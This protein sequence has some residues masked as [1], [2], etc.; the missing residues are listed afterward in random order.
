ML[1]LKASLLLS[2]TL[3]AARLLRRAPAVTRHGLWSVA[4]AAVLALPLLTSALPALYVPVPAGWA[5]AA[6]PRV[7]PGKVRDDAGAGDLSTIGPVTDRSG[8]NAA[9]IGRGTT[10]ASDPPL[11]AQPQSER[12]APLAAIRSRASALLLAAWVAGTTAA[13]GALFLSLVRVRRLARTA[14]VV[15]DAA[16]RSAAAAIGARLGV[17]RS[18]RLLVS[19]R[20]GTPM[21]GGVWRPAIFLPV[22]A[23]A[24][25][26]KRRDVVLAHEIAHLAGRDPLRH[27]VTRLALACYWFHPLA[28]IAA[29]Q[30]A[31]ARE[32][33]CDEAV[34]ALGTRP[35]AYARVLLDLAES[36]P[37]SVPMTGALPMVQRSLLE[38]RLMAILNDDIRPARSRLLFV[39]AIGVTLLTL[40]VAAAQPSVFSSARQALP[41]QRPPIVAAVVAD[42]ET[43]SVGSAAPVTPVTNVRTMAIGTAAQ[44]SLGRESACWWDATDSSSFNGSISTSDSGGR[45]VIREQVGTRGLDRVIQRSFGDLRLCMVA[46]DAG[47]RS[48][49]DRPS[50]W[51]G[52]ARRVVLEA[53][54]G[55]VV[56]RLEVTS[57]GQHTSWQVGGADRAFDAAA[58]QW[59]DRMLAVLTRPG[60]CPPC[61]AK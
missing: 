40:S 30:A 45:I 18:A 13:L 35:S 52:R 28:W 32:Q 15:C 61:A 41:V 7:M 36:M 26:A 9:T 56:H 39:P 12:S 23:R 16:W 48:T 42:Q 59:R 47:D 20:V 3:L 60:N 34:L 21:A 27:L 1:L 19:A 17:R 37:L 53:R 43:T 50:Q 33:A 5:T 58:Q 11:P 49:A 55:G 6:S 31:V 25:S 24:W 46:E 38:R 54:R 4:F 8:A 57:G 44:V 2:V 51:I 10:A 14:D 29:R 22:S